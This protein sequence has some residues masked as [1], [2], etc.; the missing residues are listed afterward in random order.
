MSDRIYYVTTPIYYPSDKLHIGHAY[1]TVAAD[2]IARYKRMRGYDVF[3]LTGS[4]EHGQ[5]IERKAMDSGMDPQSYVDRIVESFQELW[6]QLLITNDDFIRTTEPRHQKAVQTIFQKL[7]DKGDIYKSFYEGLYCTPCEAFW[8]E[9]QLVDGNCPDCGR[10]VEHVKEES[11]FFKLS[12]Y[13][14]PL[15]RYIEENPDFIQPASRRHEMVNFIKSGLE[16]LCVSRTTFQWGVPVPFAPGH[17]VYVWFDAL[18]NYLSALGWQ[19]GDPRFEHYWPHTVHLMAKDIVRFHSVIWPIV[20]MAADIPLPRTIFGHGWLLLEGG[21]MSKSKGNVVDP[22]VLID[23]YGVDAVR[24]YLLRELPN[25]GD[26]YYSEDDLINRINT[27]LANDLGNLISR[28]LGMVQKYQGGFIAAAGIPQGPDSD[29]INCAM[30]VKDELEDQLERLDFSNALTAIWK[31]V[32]RANRYVD[33]TTPWNLVRDPGKKERLQTVLY[34]LSEAVRLLTI[35]CLPF[36]PVFPERVFEQF[37]IA[38]RLDLQTWDSTGEWGLL[39]ADLQ[40]ETGPG[41]FPRIQVEEDKEKLS[42]KPQEEKPQ[43]QRKPQKPQITIDD[44]DRVDLRVALVKNVEKIKG[45]D[46]LLKVE[47]DL[48]SETRTVVAGIAQ[49]YTPDSL[50][51]KRVVIVANLAPVKLRGVTSSGMILAASEGDDLGVLTVEREIP[52]G[53]TVK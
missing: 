12:K 36:M 8:L 18:V 14:D 45:A 30:Q 15:L 47:L 26:S 29:L 34:N 7:Y 41:V 19:D 40:V 21:K 42:V 37:G 10:P 1:T 9:R 43:K 28:T 38:G 31:L 16:D 5:K 11:Y 39:P 50:V 23:R 27:D 22:L 46:R 52:P 4:D 17:V 25:G 20:L 32:R 24:Y 35:W 2:C 44:F 33:E 49:H 48:G 51:G 13:Q 53:A 3:F 6:K